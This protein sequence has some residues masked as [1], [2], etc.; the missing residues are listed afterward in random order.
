VVGSPASR[1]WA[2]VR[3]SWLWPHDYGGLRRTAGGGRFRRGGRQ[4][5]HP[6][7]TWLRQHRSQFHDPVARLEAAKAVLV[8]RASMASPA[9]PAAPQSRR[10]ATQTK[11]ANT[12]TACTPA[13]ATDVRGIDEV[14]SPEWCDARLSE[15][16]VF[17]AVEHTAKNPACVL[18]RFLVAQLGS[19]RVEVRDMG[20]LVVGRDLERASGPRRV[21]TEDERDVSALESLC[22]RIG[23]LLAFERCGEFE[24]PVPLLDGE[25]GFLGHAH[26]PPSGDGG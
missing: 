16:S 1:R 25:I 21:L 20:P 6:R 26:A 17:D 23:T 3:L 11:T 12:T 4:T 8:R 7:P 15:T 19:G 18:D 14:K 2:R 10:R 9:R 22:L 13:Q 24:K 5:V